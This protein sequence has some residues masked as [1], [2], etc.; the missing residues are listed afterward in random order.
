LLGRLLP[1]RLDFSREV[2]DSGSK[3]QDTSSASA[4]SQAL[5]GSVSAADVAAIIR[6]NLSQNLEASMISVAEEDVRF[7][8]VK[9]S[10]RV[11][12]IGEYQ[13]EVR[14]KGSDEAVKRAVRV[15]PKSS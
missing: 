9:E 2:I 8:G 7:V 15:Q 5:F 1:P 13:I 11:K 3:D 10:D 4:G 14:V 12:H 6:Q